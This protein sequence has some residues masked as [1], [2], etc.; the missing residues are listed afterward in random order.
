MVR[1]KSWEI[2]DE[3]WN[4]FKSLLPEKERDPNKVYKRAPGG[5]RHRLEPRKALEGIF[6]VLRTGIQWKALPKEQ[7]GASSAVHRYFMA[8]AQ[9]GIFQKMWEVGLELYDELNGIDWTWLSID[10]CMT[11]APL[12]KESVAPNPTDRGGK[13]EQASHPR[14]RDACAFIA[15]RKSNII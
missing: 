15:F 13:W 1:K 9:A 7:F 11:K 8:W 12:A 6:Y 2:T 14:R 10:G 5:G 4:E 3:F